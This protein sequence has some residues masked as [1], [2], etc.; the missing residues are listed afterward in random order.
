MKGSGLMVCF[1]RNLRAGDL[2]FPYFSRIFP[3]IRIV[4]EMMACLL[5]NVLVVCPG[6]VA[7]QSLS[8]IDLHFH[9]ANEL[10]ID[11]VVKEM[12]MLDV[13]KAGN[14]A[15]SA[16][17]A[18]AL[19]WARRYPDRF[20]PF[21]GK[22]A[23]RGFIRSDGEQA[24]TLRAP[25]VVAYLRQLE[26]ALK[27]G[28]FKGI[29]EINVFGGTGGA[30][31]GN[32]FPADSPL[33]QRFWSLSVAHRVPVIIHMDARDETVNEMERLVSSDRQGTMVW[34]HAGGAGPTLIRR[35]FK[36]HSNLYADLSGRAFHILGNTEWKA[37]LEEYSDR[38]FLGT[39]A[40]NFPQFSLGIGR[41]RKV[42]Q[43]LSPSTASKLAH[44]N[45]ERLLN[46]GR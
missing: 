10:D 16:P 15:R 34:A 35:L 30:I 31:A 12:N 3:G 7:A 33:M 11:A 29:G 45:A 27:A 1:H 2:P 38:F 25:G 20:I 21:A 46:L 6:S 19:D 28:Q 39:D 23:I 4:S 14:T 5:L 9:F 40:P 32:V 42:L 36:A 44:E 26:A 8:I 13:S 41:W 43:Q 18:L 17:D 24:W 37:L 22:E